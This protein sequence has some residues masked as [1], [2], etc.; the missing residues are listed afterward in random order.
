[1]PECGLPS[2]GPSCNSLMASGLKMAA[3]SLISLNGEEIFSQMGGIPVT[4]LLSV[5]NQLG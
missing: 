5:N 3:V 2:P 1:M 4:I